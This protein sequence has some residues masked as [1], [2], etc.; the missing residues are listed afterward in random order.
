MAHHSSKPVHLADYAQAG[1]VLWVL[2]ILLI[3]G[4]DLFTAWLR[5]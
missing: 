4:V 3:Y 5:Q 1:I 2:A